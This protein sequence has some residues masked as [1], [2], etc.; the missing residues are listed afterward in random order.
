MEDNAIVNLRHYT[1]QHR[2]E[3]EKLLASHRWQTAL[4]SGLVEEVQEE[5]IEPGKPRPFI[6]TVVDQ[7]REFNQKRVGNLIAQ[8]HIDEED[9]FAELSRWPL[10]IKDPKISFFGMNLTYRC[11]FIPRCIY[12][13]Q[14]QVESTVGLDGW[15]CMIEEIT[16]NSDGEG[17]YIY[18]TGGEPLVLGEQIWGDDGLIRFATERSARVNVNTNATLITPEV[19]LRFIKGGLGI[20]HISLDTSDPE[21]QNELFGNSS[22]DLTHQVLQGIYNIQLARDILGT[23]YPAIHTNCVLT[24]KNLDKFPQLVAFIL[25]KRK[26]TADRKDPFYNDL[27]PHIIP[28]GGS[29]NDW[30]RPSEEEFRR[31]Y[32]EIWNRVCE[33][34]DNY[35]AKLGVPQGKRG[36]LFG[37]FSNPFLKI[38]HEG[39]LEAYIVA[40]REGQYGKLGLSRQCYVAPTQAYFTPDGYQFR[41]GS[42]AVRRQ[43]PIGNI[44]ERKVFDSIRSGIADLD[45]LP[46]EEDCYGCALATLY[47]NQSVEAK[48][49]AELQSMLK[50][51]KTPIKKELGKPVSQALE[52]EL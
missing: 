47:I 51:R 48:L 41:C 36:I 33:I 7:L 43:H 1:P 52:M 9:L 29:S 49:K 4:N 40:S 20:L 28:V 3:L 8:G 39:G 18:I 11:N 2:E 46:Q 13:N 31:L 35:Q 50:M 22:S 38:E 6:D 21:L 12:C 45:Q 24:K 42:H 27:F 15:K 5:R 25:E 26:Q 37:Y 16:S 32:T 14:S 10:E 23:S 30:L 34:W 19:A 17:P 44:A